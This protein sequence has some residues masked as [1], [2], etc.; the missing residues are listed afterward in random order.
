MRDNLDAVLRAG[1]DQ[2]AEA[3][4][5]PGAGLA[6][7]KGDGLRRRAAAGPAVL[8]VIALIGAF[9]VVRVLAGL[10]HGTQVAGPR[11]TLR[12]VAPSVYVDGVPNPVSFAIPGSG[13]PATVTVE[14]DVG[15]PRYVVDR[16]PALL[17]RDPATGRWLVV[18]VQRRHEGWTG[19]YS[20]RVPAAGLAQHLLVVP[21][22]PHA[23]PPWGAGQM[24][25]RV[26]A[27]RRLLAA[28]DGP[29]A[30]LTAGIGAWDYTGAAPI[31]VPRGGHRELS[32]TVRNPVG[33]GYRLRLFL[34]AFLCPGATCTTK[35][36]G[37]DVQWLN[38]GVWQDLTASAW[39]TPGNGERLETV[40]LAPRAAL[41]VRFRV[42]M[43]ADG[44]ATTG[45]LVMDVQ[46]DRESFPGP[47]QLYAPTSSSV[48]SGIITTG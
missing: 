48:D 47:S 10:G 34:Y 40:L 29:H 45:E 2:V 15:R 36:H 25:V 21:P 14:V 35:P 12:L 4:R 33:I 1:A 38:A 30:R 13:A 43:S 3:A 24:R 16:Q 7:A 42:I 26:L 20:V 31:S 39:V 11:D 37:I 44:P 5:P 17:R 27:G 22:A 28:Q 23:A 9:A 41:T 6:R 8:V 46:P 32:F 18:A 19:R